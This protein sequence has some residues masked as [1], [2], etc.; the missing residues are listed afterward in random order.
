MSIK[1]TREQTRHLGDEVSTELSM[2]YSQIANIPHIS[3]YL[4]RGKQFLDALFDFK[5]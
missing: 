2:F 4:R 1:D 3:H 5:F